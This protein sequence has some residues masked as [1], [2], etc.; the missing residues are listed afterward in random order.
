MAN[1]SQ[2]GD[3]YQMVGPS[4]SFITEPGYP[5]GLSYTAPNSTG[6]RDDLENQETPE[7]APERPKTPPK[8]QSSQLYRSGSDLG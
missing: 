7:T 8:D 4:P 3:G 5:E 1:L 2:S 6:D